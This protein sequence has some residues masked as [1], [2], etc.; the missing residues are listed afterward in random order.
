MVLRNQLRYCASHPRCWVL[1]W[2]TYLIIRG[3]D[4][5]TRTWDGYNRGE[6]DNV[7]VNFDWVIGGDIFFDGKRDKI[8]YL[9]S[10]IKLRVVVPRRQI[11]SP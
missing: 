11:A 8:M 2:D 5:S 7:R 4:S 9:T 6:K 10:G 1:L 3:L